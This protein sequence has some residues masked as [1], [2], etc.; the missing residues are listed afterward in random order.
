MAAND[1]PD[2]RRTMERG[3]LPENLPSVI[4]SKA[5]FPHFEE[6]NASYLVTT[7]RSGRVSP[8][9]ASKR[10]FQRR[11]FGLPHPIFIHDQAAFLG[12]HWDEILPGLEAA[13]GSLSRPSFPIHGPRSTKITPHSSLPR[14]RLEALSQFKF[15]LVTDVSRCFPSI[16]THSIPWAV[17]DKAASKE[18]TKSNSSTIFGNRLDF[19]VRQAQDRQTIGIPVGP[20]TSRV[21]SEIILSAVDREFIRRS[22]AKGVTYRRHVDDY[23]IG[24]AS[25]EECERHLQVLREALREYE[26][27]INEL[28]TRIVNT[29]VVFGEAW[30]FE[31]AEELAQ[32]FPSYGQPR[33]DQVATLGKILERA[34]STNDDGVIRHTIRK[35]DERHS[36]NTNWK[37]LEHFLAQ[38]A[39][40]YPHSFDYVARV[41]AWRLRK[42]LAINTTLWAEVTRQVAGHASMLGRDSEVLWSLWLMK[43]LNLKANKAMSTLM[44]RT[45]SPIVSAFLA[46]MHAHG[47]TTDR[48]IRNELWNSVEGNHFTG[49]F[50]PLTLELMALGYAKPPALDDGGGDDIVKKL[51]TNGGTLFDWGAAPAVFERTERADI[52]DWLR[53][54]G[55]DEAIEDYTSDYDDDEEEDAEDDAASQAPNLPDLDDTL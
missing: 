30:A 51:H 53:D 54:L 6:F 10:G 12:K 40:Q 42:A 17:H 29:S 45:N 21:I 5:L 41:V 1:K 27:D 9:N 26:L 18:D 35:L 23:W 34:R 50:W 15:C 13:S 16:Y 7:K 11:L 47:L 44:M 33:G 19:A 4:T 38:C 37:V 32:A 49:P 43:E 48:Q 3:L 2:L 55:P 31:V 20:D 25:V 52:D 22:G 46:H 28:K 14:A 8:Y 24:G 36:W 39:V